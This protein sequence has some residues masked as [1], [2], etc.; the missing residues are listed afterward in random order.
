MI[1][2]EDLK[3]KDFTMADR[4][5]GLDRR[6]SELVLSKLAKLHA[7]SFAIAKDDAKVFEKCN[8]GMVKHDIAHPDL[9]IG[10]FEKGVEA[11]ASVSETWPE[12][13]TIMRKLKII[14]VNPFRRR[15]GTGS[16]HHLYPI[17]KT[18]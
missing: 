17:R 2:F 4:N 13:E 11:L 3:E 10:M 1:V 8:F 7:A 12:Q 5:V 15:V 6:H 14:Q 16:S 9:Y 18:S